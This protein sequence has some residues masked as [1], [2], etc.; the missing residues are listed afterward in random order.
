MP[1]KNNLAAPEHP[2][3]ANRNCYISMPL[4]MEIFRES[5]SFFAHFDSILFVFDNKLRVNHCLSD[6]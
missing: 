5:F 6:F 3:H 2:N 4:A 1:S